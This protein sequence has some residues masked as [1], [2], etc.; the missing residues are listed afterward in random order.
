MTVKWIVLP[1]LLP[2]AAGICTALLP[3]GSEKARERF[4]ACAVTLNSLVIAALLWLHPA[5]TLTLITLAGDLPLALKLDGLGYVFLGLIA[6]L[7]PPAVFY[8]FEYMEHEENLPR[9]FGFYTM[10][11]GVTAGVALS[12]NLIT[13]YFFYELLTLVT[14]PLV[15]HEG[16]RRSMSAGRKYIL[17]SIGGAAISFAGIMMLYSRAGCSEYVYGGSASAF[18]GD[19]FLLIAYLFTFIGFGVKAAIFPLHGWLPAA[20]V[21]PTP[22]TALLHAVAVVKSGVFASIRS[23]YYAFGPAFLAGTW[24]QK[25]AM[26][27]A[28]FTIVFG[29]CMALREQHLKRRLAYSTVSNLSYILFG[30]SLM[31]DGGLVAGLSHMLFHGIMKITLF[32]CAGTVLCKTGRE[33]V[34]QTVGLGRKMPLTFLTFGIAGLALTGTPLLPGFVSKMNLLHAAADAGG[35]FAMAGIAALLLSAIL[36]AAYLLPMTIRAFLVTPEDAASFTGRDRDPGPR[37][38]IPFAVFSAA[39][40]VLGTHAVPLMNALERLI[41][42]GM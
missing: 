31:T 20:S 1:V 2:M 24:A 40:L 15:A 13:M 11:Y 3:F 8:S 36:T 25:T 10:C 17:Y 23:T 27:V 32:F 7:W 19:S 29:S 33:Y 18:A 14:I 9:F 41:T 21:A 6:F 34:P 42:G 30:M 12:A 39:M 4:T 5:G 37:M 16:D 38:L 22:V 35:R 28:A 26:A